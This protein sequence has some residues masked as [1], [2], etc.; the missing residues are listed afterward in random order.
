VSRDPVDGSATESVRSLRNDK[1]V[2]ELFA[3]GRESDNGPLRL[4][5]YLGA[6]NLNSIRLSDP[7]LEPGSGR[8]SGG[9]GRPA[10]ICLASISIANE[11]KC[12]LSPI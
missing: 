7:P 9:P 2:A 8:G 10:E 1:T 12:E 5:T 4:K 11:D 6:R 3:E